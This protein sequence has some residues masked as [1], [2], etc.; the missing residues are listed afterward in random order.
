MTDDN[1]MDADFS[2]K[3]RGLYLH[4]HSGNLFYPLDPRPEDV[5]LDDIAHPLALICRWGGHVPEHYSVAQHSVLVARELEDSGHADLALPG[6]LHDAAEAYIGDWRKPLKHPGPDAPEWI[7][8]AADGFRLVE[9][10]VLRAIFLR[11]GLEYPV[12][13]MILV[14]AVDARM[15]ATEARDLLGVDAAAE[16]GFPAHPYDELHLRPWP[17]ETAEDE[18]RHAFAQLTAKAAL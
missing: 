16:W 1:I 15:L 12:H 13:S 11:F 7:R 10:S 18:F 9:Q 17:A 4:G 6:L 3:D 5:H 8:A 14:K 2:Q